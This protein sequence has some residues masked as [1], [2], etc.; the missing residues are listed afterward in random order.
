MADGG[1]DGPAGWFDQFV[2]DEPEDWDAR[3]FC[4]RHWAPAPQL[5]ANGIAA[6][7]MVMTCNLTGVTGPEEVKALLNGTERLCCRLGDEQMYKIWGQCP[8]ARRESTD[9]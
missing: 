2:F 8:P 1:C 9:V 7:L 5:G 6:A 3:Q 4:W